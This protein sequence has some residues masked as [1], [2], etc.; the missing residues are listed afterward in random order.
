MHVHTCTYTHARTHTCTYTH[1]HAHTHTHMHAHARQGRRGILIQIRA[2]PNQ[3]MELFL[4]AFF[5]YPAQTVSLTLFQRGPGKLVQKRI[6]FLVMI[7]W[8]HFYASF[9]GQF[10]GPRSFLGGSELNLCMWQVSG[11][12]RAVAG[13]KIKKMQNHRIPKDFGHRGSTMIPKKSSWATM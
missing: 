4:R 2:T 3:K 1:M 6:V 10:P 11:H 12:E 7:N 13:L 5:W 9:S 8:P